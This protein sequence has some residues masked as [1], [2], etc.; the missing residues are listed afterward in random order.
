MEST[1]ILATGPLVNGQRATIGSV[2]YDRA[3]QQLVPKTIDGHILTLTLQLQLTIA[4][5]PTGPQF[6]IPT[7]TNT[8]PPIDLSANPILDPANAAL[9]LVI[10]TIG[11][12]S[13][14]DVIV[15]ISSIGSGATLDPNWVIPT[16]TNLQSLLDDQTFTAIT[17]PSIRGKQ[18]NPIPPALTNRVLE[19]RNLAARRSALGADGSIDSAYLRSLLFCTLN[20][21]ALGTAGLGFLLTR[22]EKE[23]AR[24]NKTWDE[25]AK[26]ERPVMP[27]KNPLP[28]QPVPGATWGSDPPIEL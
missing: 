16:Q 27:P 20:D 28:V 21:L 19:W 1:Y 15:T 26:G 22:W 9:G 3:I 23:F 24:A 7:G 13:T 25:L 2:N 10:Q 12:D 17:S 18:V 11:D 6:F 4:D 8:A 14:R 5:A